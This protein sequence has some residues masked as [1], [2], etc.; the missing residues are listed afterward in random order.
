MRCEI[1]GRSE[2]GGWIVKSEGC[3]LQVHQSV[4]CNGV[5]YFRAEHVWG[6]TV[7]VLNAGS[8]SNSCVGATMNRL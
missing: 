4:D 5:V 6:P 1:L 8:M 2:R 3:K 7:H